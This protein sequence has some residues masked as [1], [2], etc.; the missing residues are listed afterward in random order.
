MQCLRRAH[1][2]C[3]DCRARLIYIKFWA[4]LVY[5]DRCIC[6][7][8][9][10]F[11]HVWPVQVVV[12]DRPIWVVESVR[13]VW[14]SFILR[15]SD[16]F[17]PFELLDSSDLF[18]SSS[19]FES[20]DPFEIIELVCLVQVVG[21]LRSFQVIS[22]IRIVRPIWTIRVVGLTR[23]RS[24]SPFKSSDPSEII[25]L[26]CPV[27]VVGPLRSSRVIGHAW[28]VWVIKPI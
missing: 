28:P 17:E 7:F 25:E 9:L 13:L 3:L 15:S 2:T 22:Y 4:C 16:P 18:Q 21:S 19:L 23:L 10:S 26:V 14:S 11:W 27:Q 1:W 24:S 20:S 8:H 12:P 6:S 5:L